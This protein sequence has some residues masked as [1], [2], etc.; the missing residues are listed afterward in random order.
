MLSTNLIDK[1][2]PITLKVPGGVLCKAIQNN[3]GTFA[4]DNGFGFGPTPVGHL[5]KLTSL[6]HLSKAV[7]V[8]LSE[9]GGK[10]DGA[11]EEAKRRLQGDLVNDQAL[12]ILGPLDGLKGGLTRQVPELHGKAKVEI[13]FAEDLQ[14]VSI[15]WWSN[16]LWILNYDERH[17]E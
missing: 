14:G 3:A 7:E 2:V 13:P 6:G 4:L 17:A 15:H 9:K 12:P 1:I 5:L 8:Q 11:K 16:L 10:L